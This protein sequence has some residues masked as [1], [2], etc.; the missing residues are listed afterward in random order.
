MTDRR[1]GE[2]KEL[3][4]DQQVRREVLGEIGT[5]I[6]QDRTSAHYRN[7]N[8]DQARGDWDRSGFHTDQGASRDDAA[9]PGDDGLRTPRGEE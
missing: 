5:E 3:R 7:P 9:Q 4:K 1:R 2:S 6:A 8:R